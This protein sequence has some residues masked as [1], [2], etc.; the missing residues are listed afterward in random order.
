MPLA[1]LRLH[2]GTNNFFSMRRFWCEPRRHKPKTER[3]ELRSPTAFF[4]IFWCVAMVLCAGVVHAHTHAQLVRTRGIA[5]T[6]HHGESLVN[7]ESKS[8]TKIETQGFQPT[9]LAT[10]NNATTGGTMASSVDELENATAATT[11]TSWTGDETEI[12]TDLHGAR[13]KRHLQGAQHPSRAHAAPRRAAPR[14]NLMPH[15]S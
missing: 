15:A 7:D 8:T 12:A 1:E 13:A 2:Q 14:E 11:N 9:T 4:K 3:R 5:L 10:T 6:G